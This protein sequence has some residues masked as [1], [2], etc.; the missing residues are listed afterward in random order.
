[1]WFTKGFPERKVATRN[2]NVFKFVLKDMKSPQQLFQYELGKTYTTKNAIKPEKG[3][4]HEA[5]H[6]YMVGKVTIVKPSINGMFVLCGDKV[7]NVITYAPYFK[8]LVGE[9]PAGAEYFVNEKGEVASNMLRT[10]YAFDAE[11]MAYPDSLIKK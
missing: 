10:I 2:I 5:I 9:I 3:M 7:L 4:I 11:T 1:M 8:V 6:T